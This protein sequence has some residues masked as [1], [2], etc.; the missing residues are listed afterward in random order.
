MFDPLSSPLHPLWFWQRLRNGLTPQPAMRLSLPGIRAFT[1][2]VASL[3]LLAV[4]AGCQTEE[5]PASYVARVGSHYLT[6]DDLDR[7]LAGMGSARDSTAARRQI[8]DQ[9]VTRTLLYREAE[10]RNLQATDSVQRALERQRRSV[11]VSALKTQLYK[12]T[13]LAPSLSEI[14]TYFEGH[15]EQLRLREP[16][17][18]VRYLATTRRPAAQTVRQALRT[19]PPDSLS[20]WRR[21]VRTHAADTMRAHQLSGRFFAE[22]RL[23]QQ[24]PFL[25][26]VLGRLEEGDTAPIVEANGRY[27]VLRLD[28]RIP[29]GS[30]PKLEW[31]ESQIRRR[32]RIR[33]RKQMYAHEVERLRSKAEASGAIET[34]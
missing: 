29:E 27:H 28:R 4:G 24:R 20:T 12:E 2:L 1:L 11:L 7:M 9:W 32:L 25:E 22:S 8:I 10:R 5:A 13:D 30:V 16:Y 18:R 26:D 21:L 31:V 17:V 14:R 34:P 23:T 6:Q 15:R 19:L 33:A 3:V